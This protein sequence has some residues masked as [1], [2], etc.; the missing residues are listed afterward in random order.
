MEDLA[1]KISPYIN[2]FKQKLPEMNEKFNGT[3]ARLKKKEYYQSFTT[4]E[5]I[6]KLNETELKKF[7]QNLWAFEFF[8]DK[9]RPFKKIFSKGISP[10]K[11]DL[12]NLLFGTGPI[13]SRYSAFIKNHDGIGPAM[14]SEFLCWQYTDEFAIWNTPVDNSLKILQIQDLPF[15]TWK[16]ND[17]PNY[18]KY[19][20]FAKL[21][22]NELRKNGIDNPDLSTV[23]YFFYSINQYDEIANT[24]LPLEKSILF[25]SYIQGFIFSQSSANDNGKILIQKR[26]ELNSRIQSTFS[27]NHIDKLTAAES[28]GIL[29]EFE[30]LRLAGDTPSERKGWAHSIVNDKGLDIFKKY[31]K[32]LLYGDDE[33]SRRFT[34]F[35]QNIPGVKY[36]IPSELLHYFN[37]S[38][39]AFYSNPAKKALIKLNFPSIGAPKSGSN[40]GNH[41]LDFLKITTELLTTLQ[42]ISQFKEADFSNVRLFLDFVNENQYWQIS[43]GSQSEFWNEMKNK[44]II[45][46]N[47]SNNIIIPVNDLSNLSK[48]ERFNKFREQN[49]Q[50]QRKNSDI[51]FKFLDGVKPGNFIIANKGTTNILGW[52]II[53]DGPIANKDPSDPSTKDP[54]SFYYTVDWFGKSVDNVPAEIGNG[55]HTPISSLDFEQFKALIFPS[56]PVL[57]Q[58]WNILPSEGEGIPGLELKYWSKWHKENIVSIGWKE[59]VDKYGQ[60]LLEFKTRDEFNASYRDAYPDNSQ[61]YMV[62]DFLKEMKPG[63]IILTNNGKKSFFGRGIVKSDAK[64]NPKEEFPIYRDIEWEILEPEVKI[65]ENIRDKF[66]Y[67]VT[68]MTKEDYEKIFVE[69]DPMFAKI[70]AI[71][72]YKKQIILFGPPGTGKT[73]VANKFISIASG[74]NYAVSEKSLL[75]QRVYVVTLFRSREGVITDMKP[76]DTFTYEWV[77]KHN[78]KRYFDEMQVGDITLGYYQT[79]HKITTIL[80]CKDKTNDKIV[81]EIIRHFEGPTFIEMKQENMEISNASWAFSL[82]GL[83]EG[84]LDQIIQ[85]SEGLSYESMGIIKDKIQGI[86]KNKQF[87]TFHPSF[88]YEDFI[89]GL[90]PTT[91]EG[92]ISYQIIEGIFK[93]FSRDALN[94]LLTEA[95]IEKE[96][97]N[98]EGIPQ[99]TSEEK[100]KLTKI[101]PKFPFYLMIDEINRG[102]ISRIFGELITLLEADKRYGEEN[103]LIPLLPYS[104]QSFAIPP[105][106]YIIGTMNTADKSIALIDLAL[107]R[108]FGFIELMP[109]YNVLKNKLIDTST[110]SDDVKKI[111]NLAILA[112]RKINGRIREKYDRDHQIGHSYLIKLADYPTNEETIAALNNIWRFEII[113]LLQEYFYDSPDKMRYVLNDQFFEIEDSRFSIESEDDIVQAL[114]VIATIK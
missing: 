20:D 63:D 18:R 56:D 77:G 107:R 17:G 15:K 93:K 2:R 47:D 71:L 53:K 84:E 72:D 87:V 45:G 60:K 48:D 19:C 5:S 90:R 79:Q 83:K 92:D 100:K 64:I 23:D 43:P 76:G 78:W 50:L 52:G 7:F 26:N 86:V 74:E 40:I 57:I 54:F 51:I 105:N 33:F 55:W 28:E 27:K 41:Y 35:A 95:G 25:D 109:E 102:D 39:Y 38:K 114:E 67:R 88:G 46:V 1:L 10:V 58:Y 8:T 61:S 32:N 112:L 11:K 80:Q 31:L 66:S 65:P 82:K 85:M 13:E 97:F 37:P 69:V 24:D 110:V 9:D 29:D 75:D 91:E 70:Q 16:M 111:R 14:T 34:E 81:F 44:G 36:S 12:V 104:K 99:L 59:L 89:E 30:S 68:K 4:S 62:W 22:L 49:P 3:E 106:I 94:V 101:A 42:K 113:P 98:E 96:W 103:E 21:V 108:R 73:W 6:E